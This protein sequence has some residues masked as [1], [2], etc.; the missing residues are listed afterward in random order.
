MKKISAD[1]FTGR[2]NYSKI[3]RDEKM[4]NLLAVQL[5][6]YH[7][8]LQTGLPY[9]HNL[10]GPVVFE[11]RQLRQLFERDCGQ[12]VRIVDDQYRNRVFRFESGD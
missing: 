8:F 1:K 11:T 3:Q 7:E 4:P 5:D 12:G 9:Q 2:I 6:S 10:H